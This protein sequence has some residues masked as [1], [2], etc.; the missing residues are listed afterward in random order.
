MRFFH[1]FMLVNLYE[2]RRPIKVIIDLYYNSMDRHFLLQLHLPLYSVEISKETKKNIQFFSFTS[3]LCFHRIN[4]FFTSIEKILFDVNPSVFICCRC[5]SV[6]HF[7]I[8]CMM[9]KY[10]LITSSNIIVYAVQWKY[11]VICIVRFC[12]HLIKQFCSLPYN[13][14]RFSKTI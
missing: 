5:N 3:K 6:L 11:D 4:S 14:V 1:F 8:K 12:T 10:R 7:E 13:H 9:K 2:C